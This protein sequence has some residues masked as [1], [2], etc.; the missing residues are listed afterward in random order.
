MAITGKAAIY[1]LLPEGQLYRTEEGGRRK[2]EHERERY[3][4]EAHVARTATSQRSGAVVL[5]AE[6]ALRG[7]VTCLTCGSTSTDTII[8]ND[9]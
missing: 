9:L 1:P 4:V 3:R 7:N 2:R 6:R 5:A 8:D